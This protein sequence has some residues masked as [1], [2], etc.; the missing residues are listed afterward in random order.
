MYANDFSEYSQIKCWN[1]Q[2]ALGTLPNT[3][4]EY[5]LISHHFIFSHSLETMWPS[6]F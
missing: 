3:K 1:Y 2:N 5:Q 6:D 4:N